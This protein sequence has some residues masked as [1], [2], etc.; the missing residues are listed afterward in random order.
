MPNVIFPGSMSL[1]T[2]RQKDLVRRLIA[3]VH[4]AC[5]TGDLDTAL[6]L[7]RVVDLLVRSKSSMEAGKHQ[8]ANHVIMTHERVWLLR[9][10]DI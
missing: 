7:L 4:S 1:F 5:D 3:I 9:H 10:S 8:L 6:E 2:H